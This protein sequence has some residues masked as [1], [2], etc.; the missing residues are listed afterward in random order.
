MYFGFI[1][2]IFLQHIGIQNSL[3]I[4]LIQFY[5]QTHGRPTN[6][7]EKHFCPNVVDPIS[8]RFSNKN[9]LIKIICSVFENFFKSGMCFFDFSVAFKSQFQTEI[10]YC[11][12]E[13]YLFLD[14]MKN[15]LCINMILQNAVIL[16]LSNTESTFENSSPGPC[17]NFNITF[18]SIFF[19][20]CFYSFYHTHVVIT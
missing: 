18:E 7:P 11:I 12:R 17:R 6:K 19:C 8:D 20:Q 15:L 13:L 1:F 9:F 16:V 14:C 5:S 2:A 4:F 3:M 10:K